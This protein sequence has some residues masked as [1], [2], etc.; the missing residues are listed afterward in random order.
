MDLSCYFRQD[1]RAELDRVFTATLENDSALV[2]WTGISP[3]LAKT[4]AG[5]NNLKTLTMAMGALYSDQ[6][7]A[8]LRSRKTTKSWSSFMKGASGLFAQHACHGRRAIVLTNPPP[9]TY[10]TRLRSNYRDIEEPILKGVGCK[11]HTIRI[12][13]AHPTV[14]GAELFVYQTWPE[15]TSFKW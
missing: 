5:K 8:S 3:D 2:F 6:S 1:E 14:P 7:A 13:H 11:V 10:S 12:D 9:N 15:D 4:W